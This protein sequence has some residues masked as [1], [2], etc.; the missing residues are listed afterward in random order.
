MSTEDRNERDI[1]TELRDRIGQIIE[2]S[3]SHEATNT[4]DTA[5][6]TD[7]RRP[8]CSNPATAPRQPAI[9]PLQNDPSTEPTTE[10]AERDPQ[11]QPEPEHVDRDPYIEQAIQEERDRQQAL[12]QGIERRDNDLGLGIE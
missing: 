4:R 1:Q 11:L 5:A 8:P 10:P 9:E 2:R 3:Q 7:A 6:T 12:E